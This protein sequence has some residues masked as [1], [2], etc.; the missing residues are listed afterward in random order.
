MSVSQL[1]G[2]YIQWSF[3]GKAVVLVQKHHYKNILFWDSAM[4]K[5]T[6]LIIWIYIFFGLAVLKK[7]IFIKW[8]DLWL[9]VVTQTL[10]VCS[11]CIPSKCTHTSVSSENTHIWSSAQSFLLRRPGSKWGF[12]ALKMKSISK[13]FIHSPIYNCNCL[14]WCVCRSVLQRL[15]QTRT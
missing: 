3:H 8:F 12:R 15:G 9:S 10:N 1:V 5:N 4:G 2:N 11:A 6:H 14:C 7:N 13:A